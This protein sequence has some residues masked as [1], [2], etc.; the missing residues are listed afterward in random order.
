VVIDFTPVV[1]VLTEHSLYRTLQKTPAC[2]SEVYYMGKVFGEAQPRS[3][4]GIL[5]DL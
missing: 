1:G 4:I 5:A 3:E 2:F